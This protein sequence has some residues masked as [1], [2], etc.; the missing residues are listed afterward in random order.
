MARVIRG[1]KRGG[2]YGGNEIE[3]YVDGRR[4]TQRGG[5]RRRKY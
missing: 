2:H 4:R 1:K 5:E 3:R